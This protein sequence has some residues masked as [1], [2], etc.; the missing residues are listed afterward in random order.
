MLAPDMRVSIVFLP[1]IALKMKHLIGAMGLFDL[2]AMLG[3]GRIGMLENIP[4]DHAGHVG[5][6]AAGLGYGWLVRKE[7]ERRHKL[8]EQD[9]KDRL[10]RF[11]TWR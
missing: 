8:L 2:F 1:F 5:G 9:R 6:L 7:L 11:G 10:A 4:V 3:R